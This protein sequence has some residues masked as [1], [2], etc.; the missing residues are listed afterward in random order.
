MKRM[1]TDIEDSYIRAHYGL[2][3]QA[4]QIALHLGRTK[5]MVI[6]RANRLGLCFREGTR[7]C[8][9]RRSVCVQLA[10][11]DPDVRR[12]LSE[13]GKRRQ[14]RLRAAAA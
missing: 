13:A 7:I 6:G 14:A 12:R 4:A 8:E 9:W 5:N 1:F 11:S 10:L 3:M 2:D